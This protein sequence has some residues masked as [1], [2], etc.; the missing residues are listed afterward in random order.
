M[1][2]TNI[3]TAFVTRI[4]NLRKH[5]NADRLLV[6]ECFGNTVIVSLDTQPDQL[7]VY[8]PVDGRLGTEYATKNDLLRR[9][10]EFGNQCGGYLD[11]EKRNIRALRLRGEQSDGLFMPL[12]SLSDFTDHL[13]LKEGDTID[14][15]N[16]VVICEKYIP[17]SN[18]RIRTAPGPA[19][20]KAE[21]KAQYPYFAEHIDTAQLQYNLSQFKPGDRIILT[22]KM[23]GTSQR[24]ANTVQ[25]RKK[26]RNPLQR[27]AFHIAR[28]PIPTERKWEYVTGTRRT[29]LTAK[30]IEDGGYY[31][32]NTFRMKYHDLFKG[33]LQK[34]EEVFYEIVGYVNESTPIMSTCSNKK[35]GDKSFVKQYG[36]TTTFSY[37]CAPGE[38]DIYVYRM[39]MTN[40]DGYTVEYPWSLLKLRCEQM[41]VKHV[42]E[43]E[44]FDF[45]TVENLLERVDR[46]VG[47]ADPVGK[48]HVREGVVA[49]I[50]NK[51][52]FTAYKH[53]NF[54]FKV[55]E[56]IIKDSAETP[57]VE[58]AQDLQ[59][60]A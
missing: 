53:K 29:V 44:I 24:T 30:A 46:Y 49:R 31:G 57:D 50:E 15:L 42:P 16:G 27:L 51:E 52:R 12:E 55:L 47:G 17:H 22:L 21:P 2:G 8:F 5:T 28:K 56:G 13:L 1:E 59:E 39:T 7:G 20:I 41:G 54:E 18:S 58:E 26:R 40:E 9:K 32:D 11:A 25:E 36:D 10:D 38:N 43:F 6:G 37:G 19:K 48:A 35:V 4:K 34:G 45:T 33:K 3:Y 14:V 60:A 23:H